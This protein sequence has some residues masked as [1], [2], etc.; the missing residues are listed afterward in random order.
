MSMFMW[1]L[2]WFY[3]FFAGTSVMFGVSLVAWL[4]VWIVTLG[5]LYRLLGFF[6]G[7]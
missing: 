7:L 5:R 2:Y 4:K 1:V 3:C 6:S